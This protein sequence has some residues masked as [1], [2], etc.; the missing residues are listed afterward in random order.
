LRIKIW[1]RDNAFMKSRN[2][3]LGGGNFYSGRVE[4]IKG[5]SFVHGDAG[6]NTST[7]TLRVVGGDEK[8]KSR[9]WDSKIW[10]RVLR[11][12]DPKMTEL[13]RTNCN[14]KRQIRPQETRNCQTI[15]KIWSWVQ[16]GCFIPRQ[17]GRLTVGRNI[18]LRLRLLGTGRLTVGRN[19]TLT[20]T[21]TFN[22]LARTSSN[23]KLQTHPLVREDV[24]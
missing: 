9:I 14:C 11:D 18:K 17:T 22:A 10:S 12:S 15:I 8:G 13:S 7:M 23:C 1:I 19:I 21:L 24:T 2:A 5:S 6:S 4:V 20:L 16:E 3:N